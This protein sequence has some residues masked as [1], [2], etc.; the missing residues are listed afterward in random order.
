MTKIRSCLL[1]LA[2][3]ATL[4][5]GT[6]SVN[7]DL[8]PIAVVDFTSSSSTSYRQSLPE[9]IVNELVNSGEFDVL[10]R[11]KLGSLVG[12]IAFQNQSGFVSPESA[13]QMGGMVGAKLMVT[14]HVL[15]HGHE[16]QT[17]SGYGISTRKTVSRLKA[18]ME[19]IDVTTGSKLFS[20]VAEASVEK[21]AVQGQ[22]YG[23][24][25]KGLA[26]QVARKLVAAMLDS[27]RISALTDGPEPVLVMIKSVPEDAD[28]EI[29]GTYYGTAGQE[30]EL[31][32]GNHQVTVSLPGF[33]PW[34]KRV[35]VREGT[36]IV[37]RLVEDD[38]TRSESRIEIDVQ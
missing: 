15:E 9:L 31:N 25:E 12:E 11:E 21:Q 32:P 4:F 18:R 22:N 36:R 8:V 13:V 27:S 29:D 3:V 37:A 10:E 23:T 24:T 28:V 38:T 34:S 1:S 16:T 17:Y 2:A 14:G 6:V 7:A 26:S 33:K 30:I 5:A 20:N 19:V 35:M